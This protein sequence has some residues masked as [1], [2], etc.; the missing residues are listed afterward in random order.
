MSRRNKN[1]ELMM[2]ATFESIIILGFI[3][4]IINLAMLALM[5]VLYLIDTYIF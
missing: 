3:L 2:L 4:F 1:E 5:G